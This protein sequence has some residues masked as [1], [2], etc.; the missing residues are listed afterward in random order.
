MQDCF[1]DAVD[2]DTFGTKHKRSARY[3]KKRWKK[4]ENFNEDQNCKGKENCEDSM[5]GTW[6]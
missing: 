6:K 1:D 2:A 5:E 4:E 3:Q